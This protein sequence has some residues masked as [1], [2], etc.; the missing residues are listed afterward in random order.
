MILLPAA[1]LLNIAHQR[2]TVSNGR[3]PQPYAASFRIAACFD[4]DKKTKN[5]FRVVQKTTGGHT[6]A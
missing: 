5:V 2:N 6:L 4:G 1:F 3:R